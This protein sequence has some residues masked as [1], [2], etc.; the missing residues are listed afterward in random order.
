MHR[1]AR[2]VLVLISLASPLRA[3]HLNGLT[4]G[5]AVPARCVST[6]AFYGSPCLTSDPVTTQGSEPRA[7]SVLLSAVLPGGGQALNGSSRAYVY[8]AVEAFAWSSF[9]RHSIQYRRRRDGYRDLASRVARAAFSDV[10]PNGDFGYYEHMTHFAEAGRYDLSAGGGLDPETDTTTYN[11]AVWLLARRTFWSDPRVAPDSA[12]PEWNRAVAFYT[13]RAYDQLYRWSWTNAPLEY[14][15]FLTLI[16][17]SN[18]AN[19]L[20]M[21]DL[22]VVIAN[23]VLSTVDAF[24]TFRL[25]HDP[26]RKEF[27][28]EGRF[29]IPRSRK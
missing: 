8:L 14:A 15:R 28:L 12:T 13:A 19:R 23:H 10:R 22:G 25:Y 16:D 11:G 7:W 1:F 2:C 9:T 3:Q 4:S 27:A 29:P 20:A 5:I 26:H 6:P 17:E 24:I 18:D 21:V